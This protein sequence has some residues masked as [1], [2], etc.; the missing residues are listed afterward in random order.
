VSFIETAA[1]RC[2]AAEVSTIRRLL[3]H[4]QQHGGELRWGSSPQNPGVGGWYPVDGERRP[5]W[6]LYAKN[7]GAQFQFD[8]ASLRAAFGAAR[9]DAISAQLDAV[10]TMKGKLTGALATLSLRD[11]VS[12]VQQEAAFFAALDV[13]VN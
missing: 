11:I 2:S 13:V 4:I 8:I 9:V 5:V 6:R 3:A 7:S 12:D 10:P 1:N